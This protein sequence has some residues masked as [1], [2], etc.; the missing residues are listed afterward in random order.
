[1]RL[2]LYEI[3]D[4]LQTIETMIDE[5]AVEHEGDITDFPL[6]DELEKVKGDRTEKLLN[7]AVYIKNLKAEANAYAEEKKRL[8]AREKALEA[9]VD[10]FTA[11][12]DY[13]IKPD[14][15]LEDVRA[16]IT[17]RMSERVVI[18]C[19]L[20]D[21]PPDY[22]KVEKSAR[23]ADLKRAIKKGTKFEGVRIEKRQNIQI[24]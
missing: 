21:L 4:E 3:N 8:A 18:E 19:M 9:R 15:N 17:H 20:D 14:E 24:K 23:R 2:K 5:W 13:N 10:Y 11:Y 6:N 12:L 16:I 7:I 22:V 1:M